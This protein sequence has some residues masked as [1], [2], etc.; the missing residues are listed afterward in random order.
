M[1]ILEKERTQINDLSV[2][3]KKLKRRDWLEN[4]SN[5]KEENKDQSKNQ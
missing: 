2:Y 5:E 3:L 1:H 4:Q